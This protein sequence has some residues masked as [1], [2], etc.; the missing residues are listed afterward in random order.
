[1]TE[2][3]VLAVRQPLA[4]LIV[5]GLKTIEVRSRP[6]QIRGRIAIYASKTPLGLDDEHVNRHVNSI[7]WEL[8]RKKRTLPSKYYAPDNYK[9]FPTGQILGTVELESCEKLEIADFS[10]EE[11]GR[12]LSFAPDIKRGK[13]Y[14]WYLKNPVKFENSIPIK[15]PS[16]G[17]WARIPKSMLKEAMI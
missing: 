17:S 14:F 7:V 4:S 11:S 12:Y 2:N 1:M 10:M 16:G 6:T 3:R 9:H 8:Q 5:E 13:S 15:W